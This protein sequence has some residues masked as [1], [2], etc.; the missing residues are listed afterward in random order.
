MRKQTRLWV[1]ERDR[2]RERERGKF[3]A[4]SSNLRHSLVHSQNKGL[5][6]YQ[7]RAS[8][9]QTGPSPTRGREAGGRQ[10]QPE[11]KGQSR[12]QRCILHQIVSRL[13]VANK[14]FLGS[15]TVDT[16][17]EGHSL[18]SALQRRHMAHLRW[19]SRCA[20]RKPTG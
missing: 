12:L 10:P 4:K 9:L 6:K 15:W 17:R 19:C 7:R 11:G 13:P 20:P 2:E 16:R 14:V 18:R 5:T 8:W 3:P 1:N